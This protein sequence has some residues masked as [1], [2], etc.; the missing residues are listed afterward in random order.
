MLQVKSTLA[1]SASLSLQKVPPVALL[2]AI[3]VWAKFP[4]IVQKIDMNPIAI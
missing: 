2:P 1:F 4:N 3:E